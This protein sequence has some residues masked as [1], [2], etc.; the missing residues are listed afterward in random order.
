MSCR[1]SR[2]PFPYITKEQQLPDNVDPF[3]SKLDDPEERARLSR[4]FERGLGEPVGFVL[5]VQRWNATDHG[6]WRS[7]AWKT[8]RKRLFLVPG[9][10]PIGYRLPLGSLPHIPRAAYP[11]YFPLDPF[12]PREPLPTRCWTSTA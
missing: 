1:P 10:S 12:A 6:S 4:V 7:E 2:I 5:P 3:N 11:Y 9:D 8:R